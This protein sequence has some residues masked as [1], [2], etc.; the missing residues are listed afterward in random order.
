MLVVHTRSG[1]GRRAEWRSRLT[2]TLVTAWQEADYVRWGTVKRVTNL[3]K[4][5]QDAL[6]DGLV[7]SKP[8]PSVGRDL[9]FATR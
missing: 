8:R 2:A 7:D 4:E 9:R 6:W 1:Q 3:R 5:Q